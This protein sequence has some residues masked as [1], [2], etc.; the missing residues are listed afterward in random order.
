MEN[1]N[2]NCLEGMRCP[3]CG[4]Y[5]PFSIDATVT[6]TVTDE[7][8]DDDGCDYEWHAASRCFC[9]ECRHVGTVATF[10]EAK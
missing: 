3:Q 6:V 1:P 2:T 5:G 8:T 4:S 9:N 10:T 7:G